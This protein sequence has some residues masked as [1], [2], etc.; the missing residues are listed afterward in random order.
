MQGPLSEEELAALRAWPTPAISNA[1][2]TFNVRSRNT[3][4]MGP[5]IAC[6][7][8]EFE[9]IVGY[10][11]TCKIRASIPPAEDPEAIPAPAWWE[12]IESIPAPRIVV[13]Q[14]M[15]Q[16]PRGSFWGEVNANIHK[17][18]GCAGVV[19]DGGVRDLDEVRELGF[20]FVAKEV[21]VSHAYV[22]I[23]EVGGPVTVGGLTVRPGELLHADQHGAMQIP[24]DIAAQVPAAAQAVEDRERVIINYA[25]SPEF[26]RE[27]LA[28]VMAG[29]QARR[30]ETP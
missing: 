18:L 14:D 24:L 1:I 5:E 19:T 26:S 28:G 7:F 6:R 13:I 21:L 12:H 20:Q 27:G 11:V 2:E 4:F 3:G 16:P 30:E 15:D 10:A 8:P 23:V 17:A 22:H 9:P 25:K 29:G